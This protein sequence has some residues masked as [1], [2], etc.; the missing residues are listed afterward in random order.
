MLREWSRN[1][2]VPPPISEIGVLSRKRQ[3]HAQA[4]TKGIKKE[5]ISLCVQLERE[6]VTQS[7]NMFP[8]SSSTSKEGERSMV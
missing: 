5:K 1:S 2:N 3:S 7:Q 8:A 6:E 4:I